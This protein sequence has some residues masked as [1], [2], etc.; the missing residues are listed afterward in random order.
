MLIKKKTL[1]QTRIKHKNQE[2]NLQPELNHIVRLVDIFEPFRRE[3]FLL[4]FQSDS[5]GPEKAHGH[6]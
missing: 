6:T 5:S 3:F 1:K 2:K 4:I